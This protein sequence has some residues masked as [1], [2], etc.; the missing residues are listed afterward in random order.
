MDK[1]LAEMEEKY[2]LQSGAEGFGT[3]GEDG[4]GESD[5]LETDEFGTGENEEEI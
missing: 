3:E 1:R 5:N 4:D 2:D